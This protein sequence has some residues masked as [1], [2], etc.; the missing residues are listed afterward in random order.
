MSVALIIRDPTQKTKQYKQQFI[1]RLSQINISLMLTNLLMIDCFLI[2]VGALCADDG[3]SFLSEIRV[4]L[5]T[6]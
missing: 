2:S 3:L 1:Y 6:P 4:F 5:I